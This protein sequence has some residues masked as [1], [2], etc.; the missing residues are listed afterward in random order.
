MPGSSLLLDC[1][2]VRSLAFWGEPKE[3]A[4]SDVASLNSSFSCHFLHSS[5]A[6]PGILSIPC[7]RDS[8][9]APQN[10]VAEMKL[11]LCTFP[12]FPSGWSRCLQCP[13]PSAEPVLIPELPA[14][15]W[16][17]HDCISSLQGEVGLWGLGE[18]VLP[19]FQVRDSGLPGWKLLLEDLELASG[20]MGEF[21]PYFFSY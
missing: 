3:H 9:G 10:E 2:H 7:V 14:G 4:A 5:P 6:Y 1:A 13:D 12:P 20:A 16:G 11:L 17:R 15:G 21:S 18:P 8:I 19:Q